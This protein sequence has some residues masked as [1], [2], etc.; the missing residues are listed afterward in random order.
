M[1]VL[2][3]N[4]LSEIMNPDGSAVV[5]AWIDPIRKDDLFT[6]A[7]NQAEILYGIAAM[8]TGR[9]RNDLIAQADTM[10]AE[11]F[12][13]R[14]LPFDEL[15]AGHFADIVATRKRIGRRIEPVDAQIAAIARA[16][17]M[18]VVTR[19]TKDFADCDVDIVNPWV[20]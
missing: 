8:P 11:D 4:V 2:D 12:R 17:G 19:D 6:T 3:T 20:A 1:F 18:T 13:G 9:K 16:H 5:L 14:I 7:I 10:F 15:C